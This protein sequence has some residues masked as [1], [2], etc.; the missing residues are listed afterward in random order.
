MRRGTGPGSP[1][2]RIY[3]ILCLAVLAV[4]VASS[5]DA[6]ALPRPTPSPALRDSAWVHLTRQVGPA[7][8]AKYLSLDTNDTTSTQ[9]FG[10]ITPDMHPGTGTGRT[11][12]LPRAVGPKLPV[13]VFRFRFRDPMRPWIDEQVSVTLDPKGDLTPKRDAAGRFLPNAGIDGIGDCARDSTLCVFPIDRD[14][15]IRIARESGLEEGLMPWT[16]SF[17]WFHSED[18]RFIWTVSNTL[19]ENREE[20]TQSGKIIVI[21]ANTG[22]ILERNLWS[23]IC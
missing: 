3:R 1:G 18:G 14:D 10:E 23:S 17:H 2:L 15:A 19:T 21:D 11:L 22:V 8:A 9:Y 5:A 12:K 7:F 20:C 13:W 16:I 4:P 6:D